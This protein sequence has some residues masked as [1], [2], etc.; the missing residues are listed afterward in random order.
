MNICYC[1]AC[2]AAIAE[3][4]KANVIIIGCRKE[5]CD[6][7]MDK[8]LSIMKNQSWAIPRSA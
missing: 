2:N 1:D 8:L 3:T 5:V 4:S 6:R 7:C